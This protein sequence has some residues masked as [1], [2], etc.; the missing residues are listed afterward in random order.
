METDSSPPRALTT[1]PTRSAPCASTGQASASDSDQPLNNAAGV[2]SHF[3]HRPC[4]SAG[5][6]L[7]SGS[8]NNKY[9]NIWSHQYPSGCSPTLNYTSTSTPSNMP[10]LGHFSTPFMSQHA[11]HT[12]RCYSPVSGGPGMICPTQGMGGISPT[13]DM[14]NSAFGRASSETPCIPPALSNQGLFSNG[15]MPPPPPASVSQAVARGM[16]RLSVGCGPSNTM[17]DS[18]VISQ[19][20]REFGGGASAGSTPTF[21]PSQGTRTR[22]MSAGGYDVQGK[23]GTMMPPPPPF[24]GS[25]SSTKHG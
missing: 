6:V 10:L 3:M 12:N 21:F 20:G 23:A 15:W 22:K 13:P 11:Q 17:G 4:S 7:P 25:Q 9:P 14:C 5:A 8:G 18:P 19:Q 2:D 16:H 1:V 24:G